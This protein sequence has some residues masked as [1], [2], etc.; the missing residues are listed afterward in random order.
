[1]WIPLVLALLGPFPP[2]LPP[3]PGGGVMAPRS[4]TPPLQEAGSHPDSV[5]LNR[6]ARDEQVVFERIRTSHLP[7]T[8]GG[9]SQCDERIGRMC[10]NHDAEDRDWIPLPEP[11]AV[12][13]RRGAFLSLLEEVSAIIPGDLWVAE[14]R[15]RYLAEQ[16]RWDVAEGMARECIRARGE[17]A[18]PPPAD[19]GGLRLAGRCFDLLGYV[20]HRTGR[21]EEA[22]RVFRRALES[23][24]PARAE[25]RLDPRNVADLAASRF[26][27]PSGLPSDTVEARREFFWR[28]ADPLWLVP[29]NDRWTEHQ[30]RYAA[31]QIREESRTPH[32]IPWGSD[33]ATVLVRYGESIGWER[34]RDRLGSFGD[35][36]VVG[37]GPNGARSFLPPGSVLENP[38]A[39]EPD[40]WDLHPS[41]PRSIHAPGYASRVGGLTT[42]VARFLRPEGALLL[43]GFGRPVDP[44]LPPPAGPGARFA[45]EPVPG[46][47][48]ATGEGEPPLRDRLPRWQAGLFVMDPAARPLQE[49]RT[50]GVEEGGLALSLPVGEYIIGVELLDAGNRRGWRSRHGLRV[51]PF[52]PDLAG[53]SDLLLLDPEHPALD[54]PAGSL[55]WVLPGARVPEGTAVGVLWETYGATP[56]QSVTFEATLGPGEQ[57]LLRRAGEWL[58]LLDR[59]PVTSVRWEETAFDA[60]APLVR[61]VR[62]EL[63]ELP[64]GSYHLRIRALLEGRSAVESTR[65]LEV[66]A[67][68]DPSPEGA[69]LR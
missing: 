43:A 22:E 16:E 53:L 69:R 10:W 14:Q 11:T 18:P 28:L 9:G 62:L 3:L 55:P 35:V 46:G 26:L 6:A 29:G 8:W 34:V 23:M 38:V 64:P 67:K 20:L 50:Q 21:A 54:D 56:G 32:S 15:V 61:T 52:L 68:G 19:L 36:P 17:E 24:D 42:Q 45:P 37:H 39:V 59:Q 51:P 58:R 49:A 65:L 44:P 7:W 25:A 66:V 57:G 48:E 60:P 2:L 40:Q 1:M 12:E 27:D 63:E 47:A 33:L 5:L 30:A 31:G 4:M 13:E 41:R